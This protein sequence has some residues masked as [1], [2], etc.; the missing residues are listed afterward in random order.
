MIF[1][2]EAIQL[3]NIA[4]ENHSQLEALIKRIYPPAYNYLWKNKDCSF[5]FNKF[6]SFEN[7]KKE[8]LEPDSEYYFIMFNNNI[9][10]ILRVQFNTTFQNLEST[11]SNTCYLH[12]IYLSK[13][14]QGKGVARQLLHWVEVRAL[15]NNNKLVWLKAMDSKEQANKFYAKNGFLKEGISSLNFNKLHDEFRGMHILIKHLTYI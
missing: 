2:S 3:K 12:R 15:E 11:I 7:L 6:Y 5:Y 10:G 8:L 13:K 1:I 14:A 9:E 4:I